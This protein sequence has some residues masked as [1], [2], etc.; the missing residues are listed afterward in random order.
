MQHPMD[1]RVADRAALRR[2][3]RIGFGALTA[4]AALI[5]G[6]ALNAFSASEQRERAEALHVHTLT[7]LIVSGRVKTT[8]NAAIRSERGFLLTG[9]EQFLD[10]YNDSVDEAPALLARLAALTHDN[11]RQR[12]NLAALESRLDDYLGVLDRAVTL[13]RVGRHADALEIVRRGLGR[14]EIEH[15]LAALDRVEAEER[16]LL[17]LR[18]AAGAAA[19]RRNLHYDYALVGIGA[20]LL[21]LAAI[22]VTNTLRAQA[23]GIA[24][25]E[26]LRRIAT[27]DELTGLANRR[28]FLATLEVEVAR[29]ERGGRALSLAILD[30]DHF[31]RI[32]DT[33]GHPAGDAALRE[34]AEILRDATR[35]GDLVGRLGGEE[36]AVLMPDT[37]VAQVEL[38]G[39][40]LRAAVAARPIALPSG[41]QIAVTLSAGAA[42]LVAGE[43]SDHLMQ[44]ADAALYEAKAGGRNRVRLAA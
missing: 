21:L 11:P 9:N 40:R 27:T 29:A 14:K 43:E 36:F 34:V 24:L 2:R 7:V 4:L 44:R 28:Q 18:D 3:K 39:E 26:E 31:K 1:T 32:N 35:L 25:A 23:A 5:V 8:L 10:A 19:T 22:A 13:E 38:A 6:V 30:I 42:L 33:H 37:D 41:E 16:R 15:L 17:A 12:A 20:L